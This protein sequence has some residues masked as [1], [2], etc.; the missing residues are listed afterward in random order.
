MVAI[1]AVI[2]LNTKNKNQYVTEPIPQNAI[3]TSNK[4]VSLKNLA[5]WVENEENY[6]WEVKNDIQ[7]E[8]V[9][10]IAEDNGLKLIRSDEG[11]VYHWT[12]S[13]K[14]I[15]YN[16]S[17]NILTVTGSDLLLI[18]DLTNVNSQTFS[19]L[20]KKYFGLDFLFEVFHNEQRDSGETVYYA[21]RYIDES[22]MIEIGSFMNQ[23]D[24]IA[25]EG[26]KIVYAKLLLAEFMNTN[27]IL[28]L[29]SRAQ[30][31]EFV[32]QIDYPKDFYPKMDVLNG[33]PI[34]E[35]IEYVDSEYK[36]LLNSINNCQSEE[37]QVVY[38]YKN[39]SQKYLT[40]VFK[41]NVL[42]S[43]EYKEKQY[44]IL[45]VMYVNAIE[46]SLIISD[47]SK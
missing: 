21:K 4:N 42:C 43:A 36:K 13:P 14:Q 2:I 38:L 15:V 33:D 8:K 44:S 18:D 27:K 7:L 16:L 37:I 41:L 47:D 24:Y 26:G 22:G 17:A 34:F 6:L 11:T 46:P 20:F 25:V 32:N 28:P 31:E 30:L 12:K 3:S 45:G 39:M 9:T 29:I 35:A 10:Q 5:K 19:E 1:V 40:P 23:T